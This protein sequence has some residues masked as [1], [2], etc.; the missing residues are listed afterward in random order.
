MATR[1]FLDFLKYINRFVIAPYTYSQQMC[2]CACMS[3]LR[4]VTVGDLE[5]TVLNFEVLPMSSKGVF[6]KKPE[7]RFFFRIRNSKQKSKRFQYMCEALCRDDLSINRR[8]ILLS[9]ENFFVQVQVFI[10]FLPQVTHK[11]T[12][13]FLIYFQA[14]SMLKVLSSEMDPAEI[15]LIR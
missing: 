1:R 3:A 9:I 4:G 11:N 13:Y 14:K 6:G 10:P 8:D 2:N 7:D 15:R 12:R 5:F